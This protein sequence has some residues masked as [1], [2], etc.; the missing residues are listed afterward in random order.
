[1]KYLISGTSSG[2]G[3]CLSERLLQHG[4]VAGLS[5]T[6]GDAKNFVG[7]YNFKHIKCDFSDDIT[8]EGKSNLSCHIEDFIGDDEVSLVLNAATFYTGSKRLSSPELER[9][10]NV[11]I[12]S[13]INFFPS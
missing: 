2:L 8:F 13:P 5:R 3:A 6:L 12:I 10:F 9:I 4:E 11:N 7:K 1:M